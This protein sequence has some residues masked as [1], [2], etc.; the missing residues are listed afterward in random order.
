MRITYIDLEQ[1][2]SRTVGAILYRLFGDSLYL[3]VQEKSGD[4]HTLVC[5]MCWRSLPWPAD[6]NLSSFIAHGAFPSDLIAAAKKVAK[7][8]AYRSMSFRDLAKRLSHGSNYGGLP[9]TMAK[10]THMPVPLVAAFQEAYFDTFFWI[11]A[12][13]DWVREELQTSRQI[14]TMLNRRRIFFDRPTDP[15]T[16]REAIAFEPQ[17]VATG[18]YMARAEKLLLDARFPLYLN[19]DVHDAVAFTYDDRDEPWLIPAACKTLSWSFPLVASQAQLSRLQAAR[20]LMRKEREILARL[21]TLPPRDFSIPTEA[22]VGWNL[23]YAGPENPNGLKLFNAET[24]DTRLRQ[25]TPPITAAERFPNTPNG[26]L[27]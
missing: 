15:A 25:P 6:Y 14:I 10:H 1:A 26:L 20:H 11:P 17:S 16:V 13:H 21:L 12:W 19:K 23:S 27:Q 18:D 24:P 3:D 22:F 4:P 8:P 9:P 2:E 7:G 5:S